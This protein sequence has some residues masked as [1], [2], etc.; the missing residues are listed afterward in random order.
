[1]EPVARV[2]RQMTAGEFFG[3]FSLLTGE[4]RSAT[5]VAMEDTEVLT[6][7]KEDMRAMLDANSE[8]AEHISEVLALRQ[9]Q[10]ETQRA[11]SVQQELSVIGTPYNHVES[12]RREFLDR[13]RQFFSY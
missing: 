13:I 2:L 4:P 7:N 5:V 8:L 12:L 3:E 9:Q 6:M 1:M 11:T 10:L